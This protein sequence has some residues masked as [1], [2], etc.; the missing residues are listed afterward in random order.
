[1]I[2]IGNQI[3]DKILMFGLIKGIVYNQTDHLYLH[4]LSWLQ[5]A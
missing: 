4:I 1:M 2:N 3:L 5:V